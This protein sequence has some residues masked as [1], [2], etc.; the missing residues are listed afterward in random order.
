MLKAVTLGAF[1]TFSNNQRPSQWKSF[2]LSVCWCYHAPGFLLFKHSEHF[3]FWEFTPVIIV[4]QTTVLENLLSSM[5]YVLT[6]MGVL[7]INLEN[8]KNTVSTLRL[9]QNGSHFT[10]NIFKCIFL[11]ENVWISI[12]ISLTFVA[13]DPIDDIP[14]FGSDNV[15]SPV[16]CQA[17]QRWLSL[18]MHMQSLR[19]LLYVTSQGD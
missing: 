11:T 9:R 4:F 17:I 15:F 13:K 18:L 6:G 12:K 14:A 5:K 3:K 2:N 8:P 16:W 10:D 1:S 19:N 7:R